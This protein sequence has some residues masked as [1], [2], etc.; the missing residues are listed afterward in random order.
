MGLIFAS[1]FACNRRPLRQRS[2]P[3]PLRPK[4]A[5]PAGALHLSFH[6]IPQPSPHREIRLRSLDGDC[7]VSNINSEKI[8]G[9]RPIDQSSVP[10]SL[11]DA[12]LQVLNPFRCGGL[13]VHGLSG[14]P[15]SGSNK[16]TRNRRS[17]NPFSD[18]G[19]PCLLTILQF[20]FIVPLMPSQNFVNRLTGDWTFKHISWLWIGI[21]I[22][23]FSSIRPSVCLPVETLRF[24][25][26]GAV[27]VL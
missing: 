24:H 15:R 4:E 6:N 25:Q 12:F 10:L 5:I 26:P 8:R 14:P 1:G 18:L 20:T 13:G 23:L 2:R 16:T 11:C 7:R 27:I 17:Q 9:H 3:L 22:P 19:P 21:F